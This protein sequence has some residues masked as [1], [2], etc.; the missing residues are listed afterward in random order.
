MTH[1][2]R[3]KL[4]T[5]FILTLGLGI[6]PFA[7]YAA[8]NLAD[9]WSVK[10]DSGAGADNKLTVEGGSY[11]FVM[12]GPPS[13]NAAFYNPAWTSNGNHTFTA[14]FT[15]NTKATH[16]TSYGIMFGGSKMD[17]DN[18]EYSYF[19][20]RQSNDFYIANRS[21]SKSTA[22]V[23]WTANAA[24]HPAGADGKQT[25]TLSVQV[26]GNNVIFSVNGTEVN[27]QPTSAVH[28]NGLYGFRIGHR[29]DIT[30]TD[31]KK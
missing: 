1:I 5:R 26:M 2:Q 10:A 25:N 20:I 28:A 29:L 9:G 4:A 31:I 8:G 21:G 22:V 13:N 14:T 18:E 30:A 27:R 19:L 15:E 17:S 6:V 24:I 7:I 16:P 3:S 12:A 23:P 11:H